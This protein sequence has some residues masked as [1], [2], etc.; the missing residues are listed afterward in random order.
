MI[1]AGWDKEKG[2][3]Y[4]KGSG[5]GVCTRDKALSEWVN[6]ESSRR[7]HQQVRRVNNSSTR[8]HCAQVVTNTRAPGITIY[9]CSCTKYCC[10]RES[11]TNKIVAIVL[12]YYHHLSIA[13]NIRP[14]LCCYTYAI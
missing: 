12:M 13:T 9:P 10:P 5:N 7:W 1:R 6:N 4:S 3:G 8:H 14:C 2:G 11:E